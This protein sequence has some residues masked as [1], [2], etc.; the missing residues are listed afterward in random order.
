MKRRVHFSANKIFLINKA[1]EKVK[2]KIR[3]KQ[4]KPTIKQSK[5]KA[6][7]PKSRVTKS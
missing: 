6:K 1:L 4:Q 2:K 7:G 3:W 5:Q